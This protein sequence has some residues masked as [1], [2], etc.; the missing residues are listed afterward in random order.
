MTDFSLGKNTFLCADVPN[1]TNAAS[2]QYA[3]GVFTAAGLTWDAQWYKDLYR[4][5]TVADRLYGLFQSGLNFTSSNV[6]KSCDIFG[7]CTQCTVNAGN[8]NAPICTVSSGSTLVQA[9]SVEAVRDNL[10]DP[11]ALIGPGVFTATVRYERPDAYVPGAEPAAPT[12]EWLTIDEPYAL[13]DDAVLASTRPFAGDFTEASTEIEWGESISATAYYVGWTLTDTADLADLTLYAAPGIH[14]QSLP[15]QGRY[16]AH[17][18]AV[19]AEG[20]ASVFTLGPV[21]FDGAPPASY[22]NWDEF[23]PG[24]PYWLWQDALSATG[25]ACNVLGQEDRANIFSGGASARSGLQPSTAPGTMNGWPCIGTACTWRPTAISISI[26]TPKRAA[27][28]R[29]RPVHP[30][31]PGQSLVVMP[32]RR[33]YQSNAVDRMLADFAV[34][35]EDSQNVRLLSWNGSAWQDASLAQLKFSYMDGE[36]ILWLS[37]AALGVNPNAVDVSLVGFVSEENSME[38]WATMPGNNPLSSPAMLPS[39]LPAAL[40]VSRTLLNLQTSMRLSADPA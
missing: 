1:A 24:Q 13:I 6:A 35:I 3:A 20:E 12:S 37:L 17:V 11:T 22:L 7:N 5:R 10:F 2:A 19:D 15:D 31:C 9:A 23:G 8:V 25:Q 18:V 26:W 40:D 32:E 30:H 38:V 34:I 27:P 39:H 28:S 21:Y 36:A 29:L 16:Y 33:R 14:T 4:G